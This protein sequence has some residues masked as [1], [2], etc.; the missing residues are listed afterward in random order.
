[1]NKRQNATPTSTDDFALGSSH[2]GSED[3]SGLDLDF[4]I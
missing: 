1:M 3:T 4:D 2:K